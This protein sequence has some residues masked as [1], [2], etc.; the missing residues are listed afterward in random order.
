VIQLFCPSRG[1][2][3]AAG[4]LLATF[5]ATK[6]DSE[7]VFLVDDDDP[8]RGDYPGPSSSDSIGRSRHSSK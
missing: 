6:R 4:E 7:L 8:T 3:R 5:L 1:R 2:P